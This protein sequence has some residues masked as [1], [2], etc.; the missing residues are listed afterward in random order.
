[1]AFESIPFGTTAQNAMGMPVAFCNAIAFDLT[2]AKRLIFVSGQL[3]V[4]EHRQIV[5]KGNVAAQTEQVLKNI[6]RNL[7]Q[8]GGSMADVVQVTVFV[9]DMSGLREIHEVRLRY[10]SEPYPTSTLVAVAG[11]V[12]PDALIEIN[13]VAALKK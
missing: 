2:D 13:A 11:F 6:Q 7:E 8:L 4:D 1:V 3:A 9:K 10:F 5:G 12:H